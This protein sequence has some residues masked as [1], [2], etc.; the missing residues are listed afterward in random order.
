MDLQRKQYSKLVEW[1]ET[2]RGKTA[3]LIEG[4]R[5]VGKSTMAERLGKEHYRSYIVIDFAKAPKRIK[6]NFEE[7]LN[8]LDVFFQTISLEYNTQLHRRESLIIFDEIQRFPK[9]REAL[10]Y[11]VADGRYD[12]L[13]TGSLISIKENV[14]GIV[15]PSEERKLPLHPLDFEEFCNAQGEQLL[16]EHIRECWD[17]RTPLADAFHR[18]AMRLFREYL[19]VGGMP[20]SVVAYLENE[21]SFIAAD[22]QKRQILTLYRDDVHKAARRYRS[23]VSALFEGIP[24]FLSTHEKKVVLRQMEPGAVFDKYDDPLFWLGDSMMCNLCYRCDDPSVGLALNQNESAVKCYMAD[25]GLLVSLAF[26]ENEI[27]EE[28]LYKEIM[29]GKLSLNEGMLHEN[30]IAQALVAQG[31]KLYFYTHYADE[32]HRNDIEVDFLISMGGK[33]KYKVCPVEVKSSKN[34]TKLSYERFKKRFGV[35]VGEGIVVHPK[36][37][38]QDEWGWRIPSYMTFCAL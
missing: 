32:K 9:A 34:Y 37:L 23:R 10:K 1:K 35:R 18:K 28:Q 7:N 19:L 31:K 12:F 30:A 15:I 4:A 11:L 20:Q 17:A 38:Q 27:A 29:D 25:T 24:G 33:T 22:D 16:I 8:N 26:S 6:D 14:E 21:R 2:S 13:E 36:Q 3:I 5:R